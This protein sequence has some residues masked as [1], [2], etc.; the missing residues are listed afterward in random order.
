VVVQHRQLGIE[1]QLVS[2][3]LATR[4]RARPRARAARRFEDVLRDGDRL[5]VV[6]TMPSFLGNSRRTA[7]AA[8]STELDAAADRARELAVAIVPG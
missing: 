8:V 5:S 7:P 2:C 1:R 6:S 4:R 3:G